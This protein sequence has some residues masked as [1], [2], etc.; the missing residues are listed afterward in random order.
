M[1]EE[2][3]L[4]TRRQLFRDGLLIRIVLGS[5][6]ALV[7]AVFGVAGL[8]PRA[9]AL[10]AIVIL[11]LLVLIN[12]PYWIA[13]KRAGFPLS[14]FAVHW[15]VDIVFLTVM[16]HYIGGI[17]APYATLAYS[18]LVLFAAVSESRRVSIRLA[19]LS[20]MS[21]GT[22]VAL[23]TSGIVPRVG[24]VWDHHFSP[25]AQAVS[26][27]ISVVFVFAL[28]F[29]G[30]TLA[31]QLKQ[32]LAELRLASARVEEQNRELE[33][34]VAERTAELAA[35]TQEIADLVHIMS[36]DLKN[37]AVGATETARQLATRESDRLSERGKEYTQ[38]LLDDSREL[39][40][41]LEDL[42]RLF[43]ATDSEGS[44]REWVDVGE[45]VRG[46]VRRLTPQ[47]ERKQI[48]VV[49]GPM[50]AI[51]AETGKIRHIFDNLIDNACKYVGENQP[52]RIEIGGQRRDG[53]V[54]YFVR[55]NGIGIGER[56]RDRVFQLYHRGTG[57]QAG[58]GIGLAIVKRIVERYGGTIELDS[59][60]GGGSTFRVRLPLHR[61][62]AA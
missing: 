27:V 9:S 5:V 47:I 22:L 35:A 40:R 28:A 55:D 10:P 37:V 60:L 23:E 24:G 31:D 18:A 49:Q 4:E 62:A 26:F 59:E 53:H 43:R 32:S 36:H 34:R 52:P 25:A 57:E 44:G 21:F 13:G 33:Q 11:G 29:V 41:M 3:P 19:I 15:A 7:A 20:M 61:E 45:V 39:S 12:V 16:I 46:V 17:D 6:F 50:P 1:F 38:Y 42:L 51:F 30:G 56:Q 58:H 8:A 14:H 48:E 54:E 2:P